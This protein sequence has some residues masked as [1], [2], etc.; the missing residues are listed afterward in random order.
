MVLF[1]RDFCYY[2]LPRMPRLPP[3]GRGVRPRLAGFE[4]SPRIRSSGDWIA[5]QSESVCPLHRGS[6]LAGHMFDG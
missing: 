1:E 5:Q 2:W 4:G 6:V 3:L